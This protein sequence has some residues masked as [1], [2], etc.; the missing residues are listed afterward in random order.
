MQGLAGNISNIMTGSTLFDQKYK[1]SPTSGMLH[2]WQVK[3]IYAIYS[4]ILNLSGMCCT[5][6]NTAEYEIHGECC[7]MCAP[8]DHVFK[9]CD[10]QSGTQCKVCTGSTYTDV[11]NGLTACLP[12][13]VCDEGNGVHVK[14]KCSST[15]DALCEPLSGYYC[16]ETQDESCR[17]AREHSTCLPG[18]Y[19]YQNGTALMDTVCKDCPEETYSDGSFMRCKPH[20]KCESLGQITITQGTQQS[21]AV[22]SHQPSNWGLIIGILV[23]SL[24]VVVIL[25]VLLWKKKKKN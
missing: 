17:K 11:P 21:D 10:S 22:C 1:K 5:T 24:L 19:I 13:A 16:I 7:P 2:I 3:R 20:T 18:Q 12:C 14:H 9:H 6:C 23:P 25:S 4:V 8:G 15:S